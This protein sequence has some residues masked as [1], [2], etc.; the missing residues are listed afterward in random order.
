MI[1]LHCYLLHRINLTIIP[2]KLI[3]VVGQVGAGKS[4]LISALLG[5]MI[6]CAGTMTIQVPMCYL[7]SKISFE[8]YLKNNMHK[9]INNYPVMINAS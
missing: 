7:L 3:A 9:I 2:G 8:F 5:E 6:Q 4:S 1:I